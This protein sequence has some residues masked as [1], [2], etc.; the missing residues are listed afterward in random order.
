VNGSRA[1][2]AKGWAV[3]LATAGA[4]L[5]QPEVQHIARYRD[6]TL[7]TAADTVYMPNPKTATAA[8][9]IKHEQQKEN[10]LQC[11]MEDE[12]AAAAAGAV[13]HF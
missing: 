12:P 4:Q 9:K 13:L 8:A 5:C 11:R 6:M 2:F 7:P 1:E 3:A 10:Q